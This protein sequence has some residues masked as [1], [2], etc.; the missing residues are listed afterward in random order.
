MSR[1]RSQHPVLALLLMI[2]V[3][4]PIAVSAC[5]RGWWFVHPHF[6]LDALLDGTLVGRPRRR[7]CENLGGHASFQSPISAIASNATVLLKTSRQSVYVAHQKGVILGE[8]T[9]HRIDNALPKAVSLKAHQLRIS[10]R[11]PAR[12]YSP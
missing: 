5:L 4:K 10:S 8:A 6:A 2:G 7:S 3:L 1:A 12:I 9:L 11:C